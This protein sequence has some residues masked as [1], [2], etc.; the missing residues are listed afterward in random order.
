MLTKELRK[1]IGG[2]FILAAGVF[3]LASLLSH[4]PYEG[5][6]PEFPPA[7]NGKV[8]NACGVAG[9]YVSAYAQ[10]LLGGA[11]YALALIVA[12]YGAALTL[13]WRPPGLL[14]KSAGLLC[15][16]L[17]LM[18]GT[19]MFGSASSAGVF[20]I[21]LTDWLGGAVGATGTLLIFLLLAALCAV[22]VVGAHARALVP[23]L[24]RLAAL[25]LALRKVPTI[26]PARTAR[27]VAGKPAPPTPGEEVIEMAPARVQREGAPEVPA[28]EAA[29]EG[30]DQTPAEESERVF[31]PLPEP[32]VITAA[33][34]AQKRRAPQA[35]RATGWEADL[36]EGE[37]V[38]PP[39]DLLDDWSTRSIGESEEDIRDKGRV[40]ERTL[41]DF[42]IEARVVR[43]QRGPVITMYEMEL[44]AGTK[45]SRVEA[46]SNDL[47]I[48]L[49]APNVRIVAPLPAKSTVGVEVPNTDRDIVCLREMLEES[50]AKTAKYAIPLWLGKDTAGSHLTLDLAMAPHVLIAG[51][52]GS[53]KSVAVNSIITGILMTR[54]PHEVQ[55]L[56]VDPK[57]IEFS[58]YADVPHLMCPILTDMKKAASVLQWAC[59]KMDERYSLLSRVGARSIFGYNKLGKGKILEKL[60]PEDDAEVDDVPF[61]MPHIVIIVDELGEM[62]MVSAKEVENSI[63][64]LSQKA[65]AVGIHLVCATQRPSVDVIT[66]LIKAN[67][68][69]RIAFQVSSKVDSRT[70]LDRNGAD[71]LLGR[72]DMLLLPP[73][74]SRLIRAQGTIVSQEEIARIIEFLQAQR[75]PRYEAELREFHTAGA[76]VSERDEL[77]EEAARIVLE[78]QRGSVSLLQRR[79]SVGYSRAARLIDL[80]AEV[81]IVGPYKG[82][83]AREVYLT[84]EEWEAARAGK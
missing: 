78:T 80:M 52:T 81:G 68:P 48:A 4:S 9:S 16:V 63:I 83:Q 19:A 67:L 14:H 64:R 12:A 6:F 32:E 39:I 43:V 30:E 18:L 11:S 73:G 56:L 35:D 82:S 44:S 21:L 34:R 5:P 62:M 15:G 61:H 70:I 72:G 76:D 7:E 66:G 49:K 10:A 59:N 42:K 8:L 74:T 2:L 53:G 23:V 29:P 36:D 24:K 38:L 58:D 26:L 60:N 31:E 79:L 51:A 84:L 22:L 3:L 69:A 33:S 57:G 20:G 25:A 55:L 54:T 28:A 45:V 37:Y 77:Y 17:A 27:P 1:T 71:L 47:A 50:D 41:L 75:G 46:L 40:L 13:Q 65:R